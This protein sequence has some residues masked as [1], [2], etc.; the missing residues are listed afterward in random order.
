MTDIVQLWSHAT[1][2]LSLHAVAPALQALHI[3]DVK[4][5]DVAGAA[6]IAML[7]IG[8]I[9][10]I[11]RPLESLA[12]A[13]RWADRNL[14]RIDRLY[15]LIMLLGLF[16]LFSYL[17]LTP[18]SNLL[19]GS[20][21][22]GGESLSGVKLWIPWFGEHP[23]ILLGVYYLLYDFT[24]YW[25]HRI[26]HLIPWWWALHSMHHSQ[27]QMSCWTNDRGSYLDGVIQSF[28]LAGVGIF[29]GVNIEEFAFLTL[30]SELIQNFS[31]TNV[32]FGFGKVLDKVLVDP[33]FHRLHH[34][35]VDPDRPNLH[36]CNF[37]QVF[38]FWDIL[39]G[40]ALYGEPPHPTGVN[41]P[42]VDVDNERG[43][44]AMQ[45]YTIKRFWGAIRRRSGWVPGDV[46]FVGD[47]FVPVPSSLLGHQPYEAEASH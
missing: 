27:R 21:E 33:K 10:L 43:L 28:I 25:L 39:F 42:A 37:G 18:F 26:Q 23:W 2:W 12:P 31:H 30:V 9:S 3:H 16:P 8:I 34:M 17:V 19:G 14:T 5:D 44:I 1:A 45:W 38:P 32:R 6:M 36:N 24:Y 29:M 40:T 35:R 20:A 46:G 13:D 15:T 4:A 22:S 41:D 7:Q 11:F 47:D